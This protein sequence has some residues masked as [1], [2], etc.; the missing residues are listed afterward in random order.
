LFAEEFSTMMNRKMKQLALAVGVAL[1]GMALVPSAQAVNV[2]TNNRGQVLIFPYYTVQDG[3]STLFGI[4]NTSNMA[5]AAKVRFREA[6]NSRDV[7]DFNIILSP[8]DVWTGWV[9]Q[10]ASGAPAVFSE[11]R[12]CTIGLIPSTGQPFPNPVAYTGAAADGGPTTIARAREGYVEVLTMGMVQLGA[13]AVA[14]VDP[15]AL[16]RGAVHLNGVPPGCANLVTAFQTVAGLTTLQASFGYDAAAVPAGITPYVPAQAGPLNPLSGSFS[17]VNGVTGLNTSGR[18]VHLENFFVPAAAAAV[19]VTNNLVTAQLP[20]G[21]LAGVAAPNTPFSASWHEPSL[22]S[23]NT[24]GISLDPAAAAPIS[25]VTS[26]SA[27]MPTAIG[28]NAV[29]YVLAA[30][31]VVNEWTRRTDP[32][33]GWTTGTDWVVTF[34]T[35]NFYVDMD[36][37]NEFAGRN[38]GRSVVGGPTVG[39]A[40]VQLPLNGTAAATNPAPFAQFF[41]NRGVVAAAGPN[42]ILSPATPLLRGQSCDTTTNTLWNREEASITGQGFSPGGTNSLCYEANVLTFGGSD[43]LGSATPIAQSLDSLPGIFGWLNLGLTAS[44]TAAQNPGWPGGLPAVG[45]QITTRTNA[46]LGNTSLNSAALVDHAYI[47]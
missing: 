30:Q 37:N 10:T 34:P 13:P 11:D 3:W 19:G 44:G 14:G 45:F 39:T 46:L 17:L 35:K 4:T 15:L 18:P 42:V 22:N 27:G 29:S 43:I 5:V 7:F 26:S 23:A 6:Y 9:A 36:L 40:A 38:A 16:V 21:S 25:A 33:A 28:A 24:N 32:A 1:G 31:G 20:P 2:S 12:S 47:P 8:N 41:V